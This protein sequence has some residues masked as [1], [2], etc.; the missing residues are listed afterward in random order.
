LI[1]L[2]KDKK[3]RKRFTFEELKIEVGTTLFFA[4]DEKITCT[5][6]EKQKV[7]FNGIK[8]RISR[9]AEI[10]LEEE[11][12][13]WKSVRG[14]KYWVHNGKTLMQLAE[15]LKLKEESNKNNST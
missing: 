5:V 9:A 1:N 8:C 13:E 11:G 6:L 7:L 15:E 12:Y 14:Y 4:K 2:N 3:I 10:V